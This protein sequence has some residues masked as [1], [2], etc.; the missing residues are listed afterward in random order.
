VYALDGQEPTVDSREVG[1]G[2]GTSE[3]P[4]TKL[5]FAEWTSGALNE[6]DRLQKPL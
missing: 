3:H 5:A 2:V 6:G 1:I 4:R